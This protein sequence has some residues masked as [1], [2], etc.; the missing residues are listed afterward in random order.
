MGRRLRSASSDRHEASS[1]GAPAQS[2]DLCFS[3]A[4]QLRLSSPPRKRGRALHLQR[5]LPADSLPL[6]T[7]TLGRN[8]LGTSRRQEGTSS[9]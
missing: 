6:T 3:A 8:G 1:G 2:R 7:S 9:E 4:S 5:E